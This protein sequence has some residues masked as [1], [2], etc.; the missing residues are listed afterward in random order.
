MLAPVAQK[1]RNYLLAQPIT[2]AGLPSGNVALKCFL[3]SKKGV[4]VPRSHAALRAMYDEAFCFPILCIGPVLD[5]SPERLGSHRRG[6]IGS[7]GDLTSPGKGSAS[8]LEAAL[9]RLH[10]NLLDILSLVLREV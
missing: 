4:G 3:I 9:V 1:A 10:I 8:S 7:C 5:R 2:R 6:L